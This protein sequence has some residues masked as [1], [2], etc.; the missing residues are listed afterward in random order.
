[1]RRAFPSWLRWGLAACIVS[2]LA[3]FPSAHSSHAAGKVTLT[4]ETSD[5]PFWTSASQTVI[6]AYT[7]LH[8]NVSVSLIKV[9]SANYDQKLFLQA[10]SGTLPDVVRT[11]DG[12]TVPLASHHI[13]LDMQPFVNAD[14]SFNV[15][16]IYQNFLNL[17][18]LPGQSGLYMMPFSADA[19]L[20]FYNKD[21]FDKAGVAYPTAKWTYQ[22]F[23]KAAQKLTL[24]DSSGKVTQWAIS[25]ALTGWW[26]TYAPWIRGFGGDVLTPDGKHSNLSSPG[27][28]AGIQA[29]A[30]L[31]LKYKVEPGPSVVFPTDPFFSGHAA[32]YFSVHGA[33]GAVQQAVGK[34]FRWDVQVMPSF[35][36]GSRWNGMGTAGWA[37]S[38]GS[39]NRSAAWDIVK[40]VGSVQGQTALAKLGVTMPI[41]KSMLNNPVWKVPGLNNQAF[42]QAIKTG[43]M[44]PQL[45][46]L[47]SAINCGTVY[48]GLSSTTIATMFSQI[49]HGTPVATAAKTA[50]AAINGCVNSLSS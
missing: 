8:P 13:L 26:A 25:G 11:S 34:K 2:A 32:M 23:L 15:G 7:K 27:S 30:D 3:T 33:V 36:N 1:M 35:P 10:A 37:V 43:M 28:L 47:D 20:M 17:G 4:W 45:T 9:P 18:R 46:P 21:M 19:V 42:V 31:V 44:P 22:D 40:F 39:K 38:A 24:K 6:N 50:D 48:F 41:R 5:D 16:D 14:P 49:L 29:L 12:E